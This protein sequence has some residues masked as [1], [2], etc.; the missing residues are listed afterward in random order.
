APIPRCRLQIRRARS[1][2]S[3]TS[4]TDAAITMTKSLPY[5]CALTNCTRAPSSFRAESQQMP[6]E[7]TYPVA[8][9]R[10]ERAHE[11]AVI[12][13]ALPT[14]L[15]ARFH[16]NALRNDFHVVGGWRPHRG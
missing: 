13:G 14:R 15:E 2:K 12:D 9:Q 11:Q 6:A 5:A 10:I 16:R 4:A 8:R 1:G 3:S 7:P